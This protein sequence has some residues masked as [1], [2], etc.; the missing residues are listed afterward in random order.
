MSN[1]Q[2]AD[3]MSATKKED[4]NTAKTNST[5]TIPLAITTP[6]DDVLKSAPIDTELKVEML[7]V[8]D[9]KLDEE[10]QRLFGIDKKSF[11][12]IAE[13]MKCT[14]FDQSTPLVIWEEEDVLVDGHQ[15]LQA[16]KEAGIAEVPVV[17]RS[18][19][20]RDEAILY[21]VRCQN[22]R[23]NLTGGQLLKLVRR[24]DKPGTHGG[25]RHKANSS[26]AQG[27]KTSKE[28]LKSSAETTA[29]KL[30]ISTSMVE[31]A[32]AIEKMPEIAAMV[33]AGTMSITAG[34][35][36]VREKKLDSRDLRKADVAQALKHIAAARALLDKH[37]NYTREIGCLDDAIK[38]LE[39]RMD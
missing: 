31:R 18:F 19:A 24:F 11:P 7:K 15:R 4:K 21:A 22:A 35:E 10:F 17:R 27:S 36:A 2:P 39:F 14:G 6:A 30:G 13:D 9:I 33:E 32:R 1:K 26:V 23:R 34:A 5:R 29:A 28:V 16:A 12:K 25:A 8:A 37:G 20:S 3:T 38:K